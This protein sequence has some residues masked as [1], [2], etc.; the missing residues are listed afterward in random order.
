M[1]TSL[2]DF[3]LWDIL[4]NDPYKL[5]SEERDNYVTVPETLKADFD[6]FMTAFCR[7][8]YNT[9]AQELK[10]VVDYNYIQQLVGTNCGKLCNGSQNRAIGC[11]G[12][13]HS[14]STMELC[15]SSHTVLGISF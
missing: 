2:F 6:K 4:G 8:D 7:A 10:K 5:C 12:L 11:L 9:V 1:L 15:G 14:L 3:Q 13:M